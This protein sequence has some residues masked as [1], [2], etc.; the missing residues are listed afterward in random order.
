MSGLFAQ[1]LSVAANA[2][3]LGTILANVIL[4]LDSP[5]LPPTLQFLEY[6]GIIGCQVGRCPL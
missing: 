4:R 3:N 5:T 6:V 2:S 1:A